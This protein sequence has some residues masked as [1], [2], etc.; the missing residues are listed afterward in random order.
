MSRT[1]GVCVDYLGG[2]WARARG[3]T[4][5]WL[6]EPDL[7]PSTSAHAEI[8]AVLVADLVRAGIEVVSVHIDAAAGGEAT[9]QLRARLIEEGAPGGQCSVQYV[10]LALL[11]VARQQRAKQVEQLQAARDLMPG[12]IAQ[13]LKEL[14][15]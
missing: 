12:D 4:G 15:R 5:V 10:A 7:D 9:Q 13:I 8:S 2:Q 3:V 11:D 1:M 6:A 14:S